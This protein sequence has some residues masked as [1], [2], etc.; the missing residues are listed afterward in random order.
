MNV[1]GTSAGAIVASLIA[2][3]YTAR[4]LEK[5]LSEL[6]YIKFKDPSPFGKIPIIVPLSR[7][8]FK[9]G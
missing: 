2:A 9:K 3:G 4:E 7:I 8:I 6:D 5:I 1:A